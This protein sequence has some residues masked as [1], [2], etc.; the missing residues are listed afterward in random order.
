MAF[1]IEEQ[2]KILEGFSSLPEKLQKTLNS[3]EDAKIVEQIAKPLGFTEKETGVLINIVGQT[4]LGALHPRDLYDELEDY[5][6]LRPETIKEIIRELSQK[7]FYPRRFELERVYQSSIIISLSEE[8]KIKERAPAPISAP[9]KIPTPPPMPP[10][11][12]PVFSKT[13][14]IKKPLIKNGGEGPK[15]PLPFI[16]HKETFAIKDTKEDLIRPSFSFKTPS[17]FTKSKIPIAPKQ[18]VKIEIE[19]PNQ[20]EGEI[21][22]KKATSKKPSHR[23]VHY[24]GFKTPIN[25]FGK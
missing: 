19:S 3:P 15:E 20:K 5:F 23:I 12:F 9:T 13:S 25:P 4:L 11:S 8:Q 1:T 10:E 18:Q 24:S 2:Q 16:L 22:E 14:E 6:D 17:F 21:E 7:L